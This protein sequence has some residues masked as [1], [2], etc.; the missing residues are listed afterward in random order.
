MA[1]TLWKGHLSFGLVSIPIK[2]VRAARAEKIHMHNLQRTTSS[3][4]RRIFVPA[5]PEDDA[6][7]APAAQPPSR[8]LTLAPP[9]VS[10]EI[11]DVPVAIPK[12]DLVRGFEFEKDKYVA[13]EPGELEEIAPRNST[14]MEILEFVTFAE[15]DPVY[16]ETSY[17]VTPDKGGE[18][19]YAILQALRKTSRSAIAEFVMYR[20]DQTVLLRPAAH[21]LVAHTLFH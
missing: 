3:R 16:L 17:Y 19:A 21:G 13:F 1:S 7:P 8:T 15:V 11:R 9:P 18:K 5:A 12:Q 10:S 6:A 14:T 4:V 2:L 20:R